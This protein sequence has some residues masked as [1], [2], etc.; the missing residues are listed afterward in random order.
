MKK[1]TKRQAG[2]I[3]TKLLRKLCILLRILNFKLKKTV[4][5]IVPN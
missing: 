3:V 1:A 5:R 4:F 2:A